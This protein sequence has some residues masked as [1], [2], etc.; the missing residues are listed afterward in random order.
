MPSPVPAGLNKAAP[1]CAAFGA[2][3]LASC[4]TPSSSR[5]PDVLAGLERARVIYIA[6][7][8]DEPSHHQLQERIIRSLHQRGQPL[9]VGMEMIDVT[10]QG[11]T[12]AY[13][14]KAVSW[15]EFSRRTDFDR[16]WAKTSPAYRRI[17]AWCQSNG[18]PV[19]GLNAPRA[20]TRKL[21]QN[22]PLTAE[23]AQSIPDFPEPPGGFKQFQRAMAGHSTS[24][25]LR[26]YYQAQRA[27]DKTMAAGILAWLP[28]HPGTLIVLLGR[29]HAD[30]KTGVPWYVAQK[31]RA[32]QI[33]L[34]PRNPMATSNN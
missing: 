11:A 18:V 33:L 14:K 13:L 8:H 21:A 32:L 2:F 15:N 26:R 4:A 27:W 29:F 3:A 12:D 23:E 7:K 34:Y 10:Q 20:L 5:A 28:H 25:S 22:Q 19:I 31:S 16:G 6:E 17:L 1:I 30:P 9:A 24:S